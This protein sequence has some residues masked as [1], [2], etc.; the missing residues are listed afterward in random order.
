MNDERGVARGAAPVIDS[1][2]GRLDDL[3]I[4]F[5]DSEFK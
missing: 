3:R 1:A 2:M 5:S 4:F